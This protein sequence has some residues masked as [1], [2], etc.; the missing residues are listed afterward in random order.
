MMFDANGVLEERFDP[1]TGPY[2]VMTLGKGIKFALDNE[3]IVEMRDLIIR[4]GIR[5][6]KAAIKGREL[7]GAPVDP[8]LRRHLELLET[9]QSANDRGDNQ[10]FKDAVSDGIT[11]ANQ[12][13]TG[14]DEQE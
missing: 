11:T 10:A 13:L 12:A 7:V 9:A 8:F 1:F 3:A 2:K 6:T 14:R 5:Q 4:A